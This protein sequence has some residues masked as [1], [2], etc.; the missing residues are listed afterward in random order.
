MGGRVLFIG[1]GDVGLRMANG[2][3]ARA[4]L[5]R[6]VLADRNAEAVAPRAAM[7][8]ACHGAR[9]DFEEIDG[10]DRSAL[11]ALLR[12]A[13]PDL[14]VQCASLISPWAI[15]GRPHPVAQTL[16]KAGIALQIP[17]QLPILMNVMEAA[18]QCGL[19]APVANMTMPDILHPLLD[20][21]GLA[22]SIGL[23]NVSI[24]HLR[25]RHSLVEDGGHDGGE[26]LRILGHH[27]QVYDVMQARQP[28]DEADRVRVYLGEE[29]H[30]ADHLAYQGL[31]FPAGPI[32]NEITAA[33]ALPVLLALLPGAE[34]LRFSAPAPQGLPGG[35]PVAIEGGGIALDLPPGVALDDAIAFN[36]H[37]GRRDG[38]E[39]IS[40]DGTLQYT[41]AVRQAV[42]GLDPALAEPIEPA[43]LGER[44]RKFLDLIATI[45]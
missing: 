26:L 39:R 30:R 31:P 2:L 12:R 40:P 7:L 33:A 17:A 21:L 42:A 29:G 45:A 22:P 4:K 27:C 1:A 43:R 10:R 37:Q 8:G 20:K 9:V 36:N 14:V 24:H 19:E 28:A 38:V 13:A 35:Y 44:T 41:E 16:S 15:I 23:G 25:V 3:L 5:D 18:R 32:Y 6:L 34:R 11:E